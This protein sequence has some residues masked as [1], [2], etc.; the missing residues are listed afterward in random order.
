M[1]MD[2][3]KCNNCANFKKIRARTIGR[4]LLKGVKISAYSDTCNCF[5]LK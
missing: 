4:C 1:N 5:K 3:Q 2:N